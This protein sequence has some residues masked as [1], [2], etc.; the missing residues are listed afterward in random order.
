MHTFLSP[1]DHVSICRS[2]VV[3]PAGGGL[4]G[5]SSAQPHK[6]LSFV[7]RGLAPL[8]HTPSMGSELDRED[9]AVVKALV[10]TDGP[11]S[12]LDGLTREVIGL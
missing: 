1:T 2:Q 9:E 6:D 8:V 12:R 10:R 4:C 3:M 11:G 7:V 5:R